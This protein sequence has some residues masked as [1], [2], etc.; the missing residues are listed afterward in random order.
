MP[1]T[2]DA[3]EVQALIR[4][5]EDATSKFSVASGV[6]D[7]RQMI[8]DQS[9]N[10]TSAR[11]VKYKAS[12]RAEFS[13]YLNTTNDSRRAFVPLYERLPP[14]LPVE[15]EPAAYP[16]S[17]ITP[18]RRPFSFKK[19][20]P[21]S[22]SDSSATTADAAATA[23]TKETS[24]ESGQLFAVPQCGVELLEEQTHTM[25]MPQESSVPQQ[26]KNSEEN[27]YRAPK[28]L[29]FMCARCLCPSGINPRARWG[30]TL[31]AMKDHKLLLFGGMDL[32]EGDT[33]SLFE[34]DTHLVA[35]E[36][37]CIAS[38]VS[39]APRTN[40]AACEA[41]GR[42]LYVSGG[43]TNRGTC[44]IG[45]IYRYDTW[46]QEW[47][48]L[49]KHSDR[50]K[51][52]RNEPMPC[53]GHSMVFYDNRLYVF[54]G[55]SLKR[56]K[57]ESKSEP[58]VGMGTTDVYVFSLASCKW[59]KRIKASK[60]DDRPGNKRAIHT[61]HPTSRLHHAACALGNKMYIN[62]GI[63][64][65]GSTLND[66]WVLNM[67]T[68][69]W[70]S[71]HD[72]STADAFPR[73]KHHL[74]ACG[75]SLLVVGGCSSGGGAICGSAINQNFVAV[76]AFDEGESQP[77]CWIPLAIGN[78]AV[79]APYKKS[80]GAAFSGGFVHVLGGVD[81][82]GPVS[83]T[84]VRFLA[85]D[86]YVWNDYHNGNDAGGS[87]S[88]HA[89]TECSSS[90]MRS[91]REGGNT[92]TFDT[93]IFPRA[94]EGDATIDAT[95]S[96]PFGVHRALLQ[97]RAPKL[98]KDLTGCRTGLVSTQSKNMTVLPFGLDCLTNCSEVGEER[99]EK[100]RGIDGS[101]SEVAIT[102]MAEVT[103]YYTVGNS[104]VKGLCI[105][106][107]SEQLKYL[108]EY[109]YC[110]DVSFH[111]L[112]DGVEDEDDSD[113][114]A[115]LMSDA[116]VQRA[117]APEVLEFIGGLRHA[118][119]TYDLNPLLE[120]CDAFLLHSG[121]RL[122]EAREHSFKQLY[123]DLLC[124]LESGS[125]ATATV[126]FVDPHTKQQ[127]AYSLHPFILMSSNTLFNDLLRP[128]MSGEKMMFQVGTVTAR[129]TASGLR[130]ASCSKRGIVIG[131]VPV[132]Y[133]AVGPI[134]RYL[135]TGKLHIPREAVFST[136]LGARR[137]GIPALQAY[138]ES[139][140]AREEVNYDTAAHFY[141]LAGKYQA[142]LLQEIAL[143]TAVLGYASVR[144]TTGMKELSAHEAREI[145]AVAQELGTDTRMAPPKPI[146]V[147]KTRV[148][149]KARWNASS[150]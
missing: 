32:E 111:M 123:G 17:E 139:I 88:R 144:H 137:L 106:L 75:S 34:Y 149:Y 61:R 63:G 103:A 99:D 136:M 38:D 25:P 54:G 107:S 72:G 9:K 132:P 1:T 15:G 29:P 93:Y 69:Q 95:A 82:G 101:G 8:T 68:Q 125:G 40:H 4:E 105:T 108:I 5:L 94:W 150:S 147:A 112:S 41:E 10:Q 116:Y 114:K 81:S 60:G 65:D 59:Q 70:N 58:A 126:L 129:L 44:L 141:T 48:C 135:Y 134:I 124:L 115:I 143:L 37:V 18:G 12:G 102:N 84:M 86:G 145:A 27:E 71:L 2:V 33:S 23:P 91:V 67:R 77:P 22:A 85:T 52:K 148:E 120:L 133:M 117:H 130:A 128:L 11:W 42:W 89:C 92:V 74:F 122:M 78:V 20:A 49:W 76:L 13:T 51:S 90:K 98:W 47:K 14:L 19:L 121:S 83:N 138:C 43:T 66:T 24:P 30:H 146:N 80:F 113:D 31:T 55:R 36:P 142:P 39:P 62:G 73:E 109:I 45:D 79:V 26:D 57:S 118:A 16:Q 127:V 7:D 119:E 100:V 96:R 6:G 110:G 87:G 97:Q 3:S 28:F 46:T 64:V 53:F 50:S 140:L 35:W 104:R 131:P 21:A 56:D